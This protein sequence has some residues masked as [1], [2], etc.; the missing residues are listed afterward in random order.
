MSSRALG[1]IYTKYDQL[2]IEIQ[3]ERSSRASCQIYIKYDNFPIRIQLKMN[4]RASRQIYIK[5]D[6]TSIKIQLKN[7]L[8]SYT[9]ALY[10]IWIYFNQD[11]ID[12]EL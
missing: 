1:Q 3:L 4:S 5:Y 11:P 6:H 12:N 2:S 9:P 10:Q 7:E 8:W